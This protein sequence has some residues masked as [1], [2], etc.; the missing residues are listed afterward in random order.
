[1]KQSIIF[2]L[3]KKAIQPAKVQYTLL[4]DSTKV[5]NL[6]PKSYKIVCESV[7]KLPLT[8][9]QIMDLTDAQ[10]KLLQTILEYRKMDKKI[11]AYE[12]LMITHNDN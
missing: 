12:K 1:M 2:D 7:A 11:T 8:R 3:L 10:A 4:H 5:A 6:K 9:K